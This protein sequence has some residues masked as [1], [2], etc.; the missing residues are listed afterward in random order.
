MAVVRLDYQSLI[1]YVY[2]QLVPQVWG[3]SVAPDVIHQVLEVPAVDVLVY[4]LCVFGLHVHHAVDVSGFAVV[5]CVLLYAFPGYGVRDVC[6]QVFRECEP[7]PI[8]HLLEQGLFWI[9]AG[10]RYPLPCYLTVA[11]VQ[12]YACESPP[13]FLAG[14]AC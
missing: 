10:G 6:V 7:G 12:I 9:S 11:G 3:Q 2:Q 13:Q 8:G 5:Q 1:Q 4:V 14:H